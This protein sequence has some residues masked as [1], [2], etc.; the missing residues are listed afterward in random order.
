MLSEVVTCNCVRNP[1]V[2]AES[3]PRPSSEG[4]SFYLVLRLCAVFASVTS[5][6]TMQYTTDSEQE[7]LSFKRRK[8]PNRT[9]R[10]TQVA[11]PGWVL[12]WYNSTGTI[13]VQLRDSRAR[14]PAFR[15]ASSGPGMPALADRPFLWV[16]RTLTKHRPHS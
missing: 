9:S 1:G 5:V 4:V 10:P 12:Y 11:R 2:H 6:C 16:L 8:T 15:D 14:V 7:T 3:N 13:L